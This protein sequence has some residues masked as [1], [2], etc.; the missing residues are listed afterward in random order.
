MSAFLQGAADGAQ[1]QT[2]R[3]WRDWVLEKET[4]LRLEVPDDAAVDVK[5]G[6]HIHTRQHHRPPYL[7]VERCFIR[8]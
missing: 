3:P 4:E 5:V 8:T 1:K 7:I 6:A 2:E